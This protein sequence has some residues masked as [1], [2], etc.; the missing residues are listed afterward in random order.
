[1]AGVGQRVHVRLLLKR[2]EMKYYQDRLYIG[3]RGE[4]CNLQQVFFTEND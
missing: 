1:M 4:K 2:R 3:E